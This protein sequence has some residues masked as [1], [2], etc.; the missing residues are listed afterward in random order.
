M[1]TSRGFTLI[2]LMITVAVVGILAAVAY[3]S[4]RDH[5]R[6]G[7]RSA[8]QQF[9]MDMAQREEQFLLDQRNYTGT[10]GAGGLNLTLPAEIANAYQAPA[11]VITA[12][13]AGVQPAFLLSLSPVAGGLMAGDGN[14]MIN[15]LQQRW[16]QLGVDAVYV[17]ASECRW[18]ESRCI[19]T[20]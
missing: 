6:R 14:L 5:V 16:R 20:S 2:E 19:P 13:A 3:P 1:R 12:P 8:G 11:F 9:L 18:D 7:M 10:L 15:N 17:P 4:Y